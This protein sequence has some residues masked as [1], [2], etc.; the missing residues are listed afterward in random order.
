MF[1]SLVDYFSNS[2]FILF[3]ALSYCYK[4]DDETSLFENLQNSLLTYKK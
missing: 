2:S 1:L 3:P 4:S